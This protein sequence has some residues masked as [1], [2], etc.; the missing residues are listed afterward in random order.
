MKT[1]IYGQNIKSVKFTSLQVYKFVITGV[2]GFFG[3]I[4]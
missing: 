3:A 2:Y 1:G 4:N